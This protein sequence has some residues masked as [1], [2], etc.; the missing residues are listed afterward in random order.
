MESFVRLKFAIEGFFNQIIASPALTFLATASFFLVSIIFFF[1]VYWFLHH[2][3]QVSMVR[4][5]D[6]NIIG[7]VLPLKAFSASDSLRVRLEVKVKNDLRLR[8]FGAN[9][10]NVSWQNFSQDNSIS[11]QFPDD[12]DHWKDFREMNVLGTTPQEMVEETFKKY[13]VL[14]YTVNAYKDNYFDQLFPVRVMQEYFKEQSVEA[15]QLRIQNNSFRNEN[16]KLLYQ[17]LSTAAPNIRAQLFH[18]GTEGELFFLSERIIHFTR[19]IISGFED[20]G[21][22]KNIV[23]GEVLSNFVHP[24]TDMQFNFNSLPLDPEPMDFLY[25]ST[26]IAT[27]NI[28]GEIIPITNDVRVIIWVQL[29]LSYFIL[30]LNVAALVKWVKI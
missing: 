27:S 9:T 17:K 12:G 20:P 16:E 2:F 15:L 28:P 10:T 26:T 5:K 6:K 14:S 3:H 8:S 18:P 4:F 23:Y 1:L 22:L 11:R 7:A 21:R 25:L 19:D 24:R 30:A 13:G 29:M